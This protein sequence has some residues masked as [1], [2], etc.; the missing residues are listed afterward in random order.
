MPSQ[1]DP[2]FSIP[3]RIQAVN[4]VETH[5]PPTRQSIIIFRPTHATDFSA[6]GVTSHDG[7]KFVR[8]KPNKHTRKKSRCPIK[9][10]L[11]TKSNH[12]IRS[13][14]V[15]WYHLSKQPPESKF[16]VYLAVDWCQAFRVIMIKV[17][18]SN[19]FISN[20]TRE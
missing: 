19:H 8:Q 6:R 2:I 10:K 3:Q 9:V 20:I 17:N 1:T 4:I 16:V 12:R 18:F 7:I 11:T 15:L 13:F 5:P 14:P